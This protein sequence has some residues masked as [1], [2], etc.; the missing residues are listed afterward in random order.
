MVPGSG[1]L[2]AVLRY[3]LADLDPNLA[4]LKVT[5]FDDQVSLTFNRQR[6]LARLSV[7]YGLLALILASIGLYD[8]AAYTVARRTSE[9][10]IRMALGADRP[11]VVAMVLRGAMPPIAL[12]LGLGI[13]ISLAAGRAIASQLYGVKWYNPVIVGTSVVVLVTC[14]LLA[15]ILRACRAGSIDPMRALRTE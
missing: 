7:L 3:T 15:G 4:V 6:L 2:E 12:G 11:Q 14:A 9:I 10:G 8:V 1:N 5:S 13:P